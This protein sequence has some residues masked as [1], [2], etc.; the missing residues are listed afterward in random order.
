M[1]R[2]DLRLAG[3]VPK[4]WEVLRDGWVLARA[5][6]PSGPEPPVP[7][8]LRWSV[9][10]CIFAAGT[11]TF[12]T[13]TLA[14][15][16]LYGGAA[17]HN[18]EKARAAAVLRS[19]D[20]GQRA[21]VHLG[22]GLGGIVLPIAVIGVV[23][24]RFPQWIGW[25]LAVW[26]CISLAFVLLGSTRARS[27]KPGPGVVRIVHLG[28][29]ELRKG[30]GLG[31]LGKALCDQASE[32]Q[33]T[34]DLTARSEHLADAY[35]R[36]GFLRPNPSKLW[37]IR[38]PQQPPSAPPPPPPPE[39]QRSMPTTGGEA[40]LAVS[41]GR[42]DAQLA[43]LD[44]LDTKAG[45][46]IAAASAA[47]AYLA[48]LLSIQP[49]GTEGSTL[50]SLS[51]ALAGALVT[52]TCVTGLRALAVRTWMLHPDP[53]TAWAHRN[54]PAVAWELALMLDDAYEGNSPG[55]ATKASRVKDTAELVATLTAVVLVTTVLIV[56]L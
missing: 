3:L 52:L 54:S 49:A 21:L 28:A 44:A 40:Y 50:Q 46:L 15:A 37:M 17:S 42:L 43:T 4:W 33:V 18:N 23:W 32:Q 19:S 25:V 7:R 20:L 27:P 13:G 1:T 45:V 53:T 34:L 8:P 36:A 35:A 6:S 38:E 2:L 55:A 30:A 16:R 24:S 48:A 14:G 12:W 31:G 26:V 47:A 11:Y 29:W 10:N 9:L 56:W 41:Q 22:Q 39:P 51:L 5:F